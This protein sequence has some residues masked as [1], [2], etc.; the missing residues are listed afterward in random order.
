MVGSLIQLVAELRCTVAKLSYSNGRMS[1]PQLGSGEE[2]HCMVQNL[3]HKSIMIS[4]LIP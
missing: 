1:R 4:S 3:D 2:K